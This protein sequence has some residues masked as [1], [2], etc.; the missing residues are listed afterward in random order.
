VLCFLNDFLNLPG[1]IH[2]V[3]NL[4]GGDHLIKTKGYKRF[5]Y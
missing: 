1:T 2:T 4:L 3:Q 5:N